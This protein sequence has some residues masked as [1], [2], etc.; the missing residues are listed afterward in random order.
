MSQ[1]FI[2]YQ[3]KI[4]Q[5]LLKLFEQSLTAKTA[6]LEDILVVNTALSKAHDLKEVQMILKLFSVSYSFLKPLL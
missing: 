5:N 2:F 3:T 4:G 6:S 1:E